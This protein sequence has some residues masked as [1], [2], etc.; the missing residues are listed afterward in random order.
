MV[1]ALGADQ[2]RALPRAREGIGEIARLALELGRL[3]RAVD[4]HDR[5][6]DAREVTL[7]RERLLGLVGELHVA[8][9]L[10]EPGAAQV[11]HAARERIALHRRRGQAVLGP[12][13]SRRD[14][15][16]MRAGGGPADVQAAGVAADLFC[17][18]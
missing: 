12:V 7:W 17:M 3:E 9:A 6:V 13:G 5:S 15:R 2:L 4:Q 10:R 18:L 16:E 1:V 8:R 14:S 11:V